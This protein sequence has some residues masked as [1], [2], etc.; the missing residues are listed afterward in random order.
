MLWSREKECWFTSVEAFFSR[1]DLF[2]YF[3][4]LISFA[5]CFSE[6]WALYV[7][8]SA[9]VEKASVFLKSEWFVVDYFEDCPIVSVA[10]G[11]I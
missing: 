1:T 5:K 2:F 10:F 7:Y 11:L 3:Y 6:L 4:F 8:A 9:S